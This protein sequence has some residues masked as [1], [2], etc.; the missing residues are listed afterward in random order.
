MLSTSMRF[1]GIERTTMSGQSMIVPANSKT[2]GLEPKAAFRKDS[3]TS[4]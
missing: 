4:E 3:N 2:S 1:I